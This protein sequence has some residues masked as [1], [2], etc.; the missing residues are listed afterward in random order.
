V[1]TSV[2]FLILT[3]AKKTALGE[4]VR[5]FFLYELGVAEV[6]SLYSVPSPKCLP[7]STRNGL[8]KAVVSLE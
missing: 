5:R 1:S 8:I 2:D 7:T 4:N 3:K 6:E